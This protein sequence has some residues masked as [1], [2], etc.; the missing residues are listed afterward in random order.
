[1]DMRVAPEPEDDS[2]DEWVEGGE[3]ARLREAREARLAALPE[4]LQGREWVASVRGV[5]WECLLH[6]ST[7]ATTR[8]YAW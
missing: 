3:A 1:V 8:G 6:V 7:F 2:G 4:N 5:I